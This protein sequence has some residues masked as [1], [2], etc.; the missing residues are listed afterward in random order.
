MIPQQSVTKVLNTELTDIV[1]RAH[2]QKKTKKC[3]DAVI[4]SHQ[5][6]PQ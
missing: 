5:K 3:I 1:L 2:L 4:H 6:K